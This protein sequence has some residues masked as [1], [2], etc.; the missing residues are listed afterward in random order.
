MTRPGMPPLAIVTWIVVWTTAPGAAPAQA[1][2]VRP[3]ATLARAAA[4]AV[5]VPRSA[6]DRTRSLR[7]GAVGA[8]DSVVRRPQRPSHVR[9]VLGG[10]LLG[11]GA[12]AAGIALTSRGRECICT[13]LV[14]VPAVGVAMVAGGGVGYVVHRIRFR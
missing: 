14:F 6:A 12:M 10:A 3:A 9:Y 11:G 7:P 8:W 5:A 4:P 1:Q 13:P 2:T